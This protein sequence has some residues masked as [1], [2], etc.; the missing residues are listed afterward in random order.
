MLQLDPN[1]RLQPDGGAWHFDFA[2]ARARRRLA[3]DECR[4]SRRDVAGPFIDSGAP[5][6]VRYPTPKSA[7]FAMRVVNLHPRNARLTVSVNYDDPNLVQCHR[8]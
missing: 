5:L 3:G 4:I 2:Q 7:D 6:R 8:N 1:L